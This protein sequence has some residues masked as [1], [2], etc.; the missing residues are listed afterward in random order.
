LPP[1][2]EWVLFC[3]PSAAQTF[4]YEN[5]V[6]WKAGRIFFYFL[7]NG[8]AWAPC[9]ETAPWLVNSNLIDFR[10]FFFIFRLMVRGLHWPNLCLGRSQ[11]EKDEAFILLAYYKNYIQCIL[12]LNNIFAMCHVLCT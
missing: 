5:M 3:P 6:S 1:K 8:L 9:S 2:V 7:Q 4:I 11:K 12:S 10:K